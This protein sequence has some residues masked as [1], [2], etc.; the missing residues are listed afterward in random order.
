MLIV[1]PQLSSYVELDPRTAQVKV[2]SPE[3]FVASANGVI[4]DNPKQAPIS[5]SKLEL[6]TDT[7][8]PHFTVEGRRGSLRLRAPLLGPA[9]RD[10]LL[11]YSKAYKFRADLY[12]PIAEP[13]AA[14]RKVTKPVSVQVFLGTWCSSCAEIV[15]HILQ[16]EQELTS[17]PIRFEY[18][19]I[20]QDFNDPVVKQ[21]G[22]VESALPVCIVRVNG[23]EVARS[24]GP[25]WRYPEVALQNALLQAGVVTP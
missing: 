13:L 14:L 23:A 16:L 8:M 6:A 24:S 22:I 12:Q 1:T 7:R 10:Q 4:L 19:G 3:A 25:T 15:P 5:V 20:P 11:D 2:Y 18:Y 17:T 9:T 21:H